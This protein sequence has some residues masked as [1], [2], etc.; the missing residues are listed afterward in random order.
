MKTMIV[1]NIENFSNE[2][3]QYRE[4]REM[5]QMLGL[6]PYL[7]GVDQERSYKTAILQHT[8]ELLSCD[9]VLFLDTWSDSKI[10][11]TLRLVAE[12]AEQK[13]FYEST[14]FEETDEN[15]IVQAVSSVTGLTLEEIKENSRKQIKFYARLAIATLCMRYA[16][17]PKA[18]IA[19]LI[20]R[21]HATL[22]HYKKIFPS[23]M[24]Y[25][26][27][28]RCLIHKAEKLIKQS[29]SQ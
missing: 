7:P 15:L 19:A 6:E 20:G 16:S 12:E 3:N 14:I 11:R 28:F 17:I 26:S 23:E 22:S 4:T 5:L 10:A 2:R 21:N 18:Q 27:Q 8:A 13:I 24:K 29:V 9:A 25:N 1:G